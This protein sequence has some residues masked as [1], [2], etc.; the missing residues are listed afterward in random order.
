VATARAA[1]PPEPVSA[2]EAAR[3][4][5]MASLARIRPEARFRIHAA[6]GRGG[7]G[8]VTRVWIAGELQSFPA[9]D[10]WSRGGTADLEVA[11]GSTTAT[12][13]VTLAAG[14]RGFLASVTLPKPVTGDAIEVRARLAG[15]DPD[16]ARLADSVRVALAE[17]SRLPLLFRR[18]PTT[19]NRYLPA[20]TF[21][22]SR[23]ERVKIEI[24]VPAGT[25]TG[26]GRMLDRSGQPLS[27]PVAVTTRTDAA[28]THWLTADIT[29]AP[30]GAGDYI[31]ETGFTTPGGEEKTVTAI[32]VTR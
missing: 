26:S 31:V 7:D 29:L 22:F 18:G 19:G 13:R 3:E 20:A 30:L 12:E 2:E 32:R 4:T 10:P 21:L 23:T 15:A 8:A 28:G 9:S 14:E 24:P 27:V 6:P 11:V 16:A 25:K 17:G 1:A 5:A